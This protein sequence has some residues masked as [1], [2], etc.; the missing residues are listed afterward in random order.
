MGDPPDNTTCN[1]GPRQGPTPLHPRACL[2]Q[3]IEAQGY[4]ENAASHIEAEVNSAP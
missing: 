2:K 3:N 1:Y 4:G